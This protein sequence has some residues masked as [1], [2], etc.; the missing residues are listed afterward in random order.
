MSG[1]PGLV[2][3]SAVLLSLKG[4]KLHFLK[5]RGLPDFHINFA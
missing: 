3:S 2:S 1:F 4:T 5:F